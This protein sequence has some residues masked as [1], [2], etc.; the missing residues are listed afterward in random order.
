MAIGVS[1]KLLITQL[2]LKQEAG[3][4]SQG[5]LCEKKLFELPLK[6]Q[7]CAWKLN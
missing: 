4:E 2:S 3:K 1:I 5:Q 7:T 6:Y